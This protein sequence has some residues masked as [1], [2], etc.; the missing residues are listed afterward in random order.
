MNSTTKA[1]HT[2]E[3]LFILHRRRLAWTT[4][5]MMSSN[6]NNNKNNN[7]NNENWTVTCRAA[8]TTAK[9]GS[10]SP[11]A[12]HK[13]FILGQDPRNK[14][15]IHDDKGTVDQTWRIQSSSN[16]DTQYSSVSVSTWTDWIHF[17]SSSTTSSP[18]QNEESGNSQST[19]RAII[20]SPYHENELNNKNNENSSNIQKN[21]N[22]IIG[23][24][25]TE[26]PR[27]FIQQHTTPRN[28]KSN[29]ILV[30]DMDECLI[31]SQFF[32][33]SNKTRQKTPQTQHTAQ[34]DDYRQAEHRPSWTYDPHNHPDQHNATVHDHE[35]I[36]R[37]SSHPRRCDSFQFHLPH[38]NEYVLVRKR[39]YLD[40]FLQLVTQRYHTFIF[41]A[42]AEE[43]AKP[44][45][46]RL[47]PTGT[48]FTHRFYRNSC[49]YDP[50][51]GS[52]IKNLYN[53]YPSMIKAIQMIPSSTSSSCSSD[54]E[55]QQTFREGVLESRNHH[56][57]ISSSSHHHN[58]E[59]RN[60]NSSMHSL[61]IE[62]GQQQQEENQQQPCPMLLQ[63]NDKDDHLNPFSSSSSKDDDWF[64]TMECR[65]VLVDNNPMSFIANPSNGI[66]V[67]NFYDDVNDSTLEAVWEL[68][69]ELEHAPDVRPILDA[70]FGLKTVFKDIF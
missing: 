17:G 25:Q 39:P 34:V 32:S 67:S 20:S 45:L 22:K 13:S 44:L 59:I 42:A 50:K 33:Q 65:V 62:C 46:D 1:K 6:N 60:G 21:D 37:S 31:H 26:D 8:A 41:T 49:T 69:L 5:K 29:L 38:S 61:D 30:L 18:S 36:H 55:Q 63:E 14:N 12:V 51:L 35:N 2:L 16:Q 66:L 70:K 9:V 58:I 68:L 24:R 54:K 27:R 40:I 15:R 4:M 3:S 7:S 28:K 64:H 10:V 56:L 52:Y 57:P 48:M 19:T 11:A 23:V 47:D 43:Y 53:I